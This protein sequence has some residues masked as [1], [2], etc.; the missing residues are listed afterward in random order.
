MLFLGLLGFVLTFIGV[1]D[2]IINSKKRGLWHL[3]LSITVKIIGCAFLVL[4]MIKLIG[5]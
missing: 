3:F 2:T 5:G 1:A 4:Y